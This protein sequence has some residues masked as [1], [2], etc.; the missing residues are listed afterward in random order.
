[1]EN[2]M[3][4]NEARPGMMAANKRA[5]LAIRNDLQPIDQVFY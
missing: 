1:M 3:V 5:N 4:K 2:L